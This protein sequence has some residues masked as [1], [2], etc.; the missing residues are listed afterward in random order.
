MER[1]TWNSLSQKDSLPKIKHGQT[2]LQ[3]GS[4]F[5]SNM[6]TWFRKAGFKVIDNPLGVIFHPFPLADQ[7]R[8]ALCEKRDL[9]LVQKEDVHLS[10]HAS[11]SIYGLTENELIQKLSDALDELKEA[12]LT[13]DFLFV[14]FGSAHAYRLV[15]TGEIVANCHQQPQ[16][17]FSKELSS[18]EDIAIHW[19]EIMQEIQYINPNLKIVFTVSPVRY[20]RDGLMENQLSKASLFLALSKMKGEFYYFPVYELVMDVLRDYGYFEKDGTHPNIL[21]VEQVWNFVYEEFFDL[22]TQHVI[23]ELL[24]LRAMENHRILYP[25]SKTANQFI[26]QFKQKRESFLSLHPRIIW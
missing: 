3:L 12:L 6:S 10:F 9:S 16:K 25:R 15:E 11:S 8:L 17:L 26:I 21:A 18:P 14:T 19:N 13:V 22:E 24:K 2:M 23:D 4:C 1:I 5:S 20:I 7:I